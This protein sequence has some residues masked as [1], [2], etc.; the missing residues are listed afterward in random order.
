MTPKNK[1]K[2]IKKD[3]NI[4]SW[5]VIVEYNGYP[6]YA[7][8][9]DGEIEHAAK[10]VGLKETGS[11]YGQGVR[12][13]SFKSKKADKKSISSTIKKLKTELKKLRNKPKVSDYYPMSELWLPKK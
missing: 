13:I 11:G 10:E 12:D 6:E 9:L 4:E 8:S 1:T 7:Q 5:Y 3:Q 2:L